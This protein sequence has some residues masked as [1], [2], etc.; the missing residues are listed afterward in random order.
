[1]TTNF[2]PRNKLI[3]NHYLSTD[4]TVVS[5]DEMRK[6]FLNYLIYKGFQSEKTLTNDENL[7]LAIDALRYCTFTQ[8]NNN[9]F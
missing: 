2:N 5:S 4:G 8:E 6:L 3:F 9:K 1:M 7:N